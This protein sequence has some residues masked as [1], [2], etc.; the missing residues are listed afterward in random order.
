L[1]KGMEKGLLRSKKKGQAK[2]V[3]RE[4]KDLA[5]GGRE[6]KKTGVKPRNETLKIVLGEERN[7][8]CSPEGNRCTK[9]GKRESQRRG[10]GLR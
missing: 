6:K 1:K 3:K 7:G 8:F 9:K 2:A 4:R 5:G 10:K